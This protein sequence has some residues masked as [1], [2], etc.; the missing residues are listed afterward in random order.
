MDGQG[1]KT[2]SYSIQRTMLSGFFSVI[3]S[4]INQV[5]TIYDCACVLLH[6]VIHSNFEAVSGL[7]YVLTLLELVQELNWKNYMIIHY[8]I[9]S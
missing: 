4:V 6:H 9:S 2:V 8:I 7:V 5:F 1:C 3:N